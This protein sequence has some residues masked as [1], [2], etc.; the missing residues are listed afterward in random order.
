MFVCPC[1]S[2]YPSYPHVVPGSQPQHPH[3]NLLPH[4]R[5][6][7]A[8]KGP[9]DSPRSN[10]DVV[11]SMM[12][13]PRAPQRQPAAAGGGPAPPANAPS[14]LSREEKVKKLWGSHPQGG[15]GGSAAKKEPETVADVAA[16]VFGKN[17]WD[18]AEFEE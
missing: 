7:A 13:G 16:E 9:V 1:P 10:A 5:S 17:R 18:V 11:R 15:G 3:L 14:G 4:L 12:A 2:L 6:Q 8:Y